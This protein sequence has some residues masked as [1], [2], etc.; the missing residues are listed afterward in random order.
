METDGRLGHEWDEWDGKP[1]A[2]GGDFRTTAG[3]FFLF[4]AVGLAG[5]A[6]V[7]AVAVFLLSPRLA[8]LAAW[9]PTALYVADGVVALAAGIWLALIGASDG[10]PRPLVPRPLA[11][12]WLL[13]NTL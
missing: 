3:K 5:V 8:Q 2:N 9:L 1:L 12:R 13:L 4:T 7:S 6:V 11:A 10:L